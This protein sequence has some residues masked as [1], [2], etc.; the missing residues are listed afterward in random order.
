MRRR[1]SIAG[2]GGTAAWSAVAWAQ[3]PGGRMR[4][5]GMLMVGDG[6]DPRWTWVS[7]FTQALADLGWADGRTCGW[8]LSDIILTIGTPA[9][10]A[11]QRERG[12]SQSSLRAWPIPSPAA[13]SRGPEKSQVQSAAWSSAQTRLL[14]SNTIFDWVSE[15]LVAIGSARGQKNPAIRRDTSQPCPFPCSYLYCSP[16]LFTR[17]GTRC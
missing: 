3:R 4:R 10:V 2:L 15:Q 17:L 7:A 5:I 9:I 8:T 12:R 16:P 11:L 6:N 13:S 1:Q 14:L